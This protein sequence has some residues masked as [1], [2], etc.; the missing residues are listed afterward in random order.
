MHRSRSASGQ[1][2]GRRAVLE[3]HTG[4]GRFRYL[5]GHI[6]HHIFE[7]SLSPGSTSVNHRLP[8]RN[9]WRTSANQRNSQF[10]KS[11]Q[12]AMDAS[13]RCYSPPQT[14]PFL[15]TNDSRRIETRWYFA[16]WDWKTNRRESSLTAKNDSLNDCRPE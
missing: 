6:G 11:L 14:L 8:N 10:R 7:T 9:R 2:F 3:A 1:R 5:N 16:L 13:E 15:K 12:R 4:A